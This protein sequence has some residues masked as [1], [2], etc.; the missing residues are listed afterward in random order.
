M[1]IDQLNLLACFVLLCRKTFS[2]NQSQTNQY[3]ATLSTRISLV[4]PLH[5]YTHNYHQKD[6]FLLLWLCKCMGAD[7]ML[8]YTM[9]HW[10]EAALGKLCS[11]AY[12]GISSLEGSTGKG[13]SVAAY[14]TEDSRPRHLTEPQG[15]ELLTCIPAFRLV[16]CG[17]RVLLEKTRLNSL[18]PQ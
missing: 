2:Q 13:R 10:G 5:T 7:K 1:K 6:S 16:L 3:G 18:V 12:A 14:Q 4:S 17:G 9:G 8:R 15:L 11:Q